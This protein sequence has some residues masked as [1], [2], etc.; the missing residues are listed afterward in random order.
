M[1]GR[2]STPPGPPHTEAQAVRRMRYGYPFAL[3]VLAVSLVL[4][5]M[6]WDHARQRE[7]KLAA[8]QFR[9]IAGQQASL[10]Q[11][12]LNSVD[13]PLRGGASLFA[14]LDTPTPNQWRG[15][16]DALRLQTTFPSLVGVGYAA[17]LDERATF[18]GQWGLKP[19]R[20][21]FSMAARTAAARSRLV[22]W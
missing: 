12:H 3:L 21:V 4:V 13:V 11:L 15:Y 1:L 6:A 10:V 14:A 20:G 17:Y 7:M 16:V 19:S 5:V 2:M 22:L 18:L 8:E 9:G